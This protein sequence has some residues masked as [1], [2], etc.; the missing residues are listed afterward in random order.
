MPMALKEEIEN[1]EEQV[2]NV[3]QR[4]GNAKKKSR[5]NTRY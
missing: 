5:R 1:M 3:S 4:D 2:D